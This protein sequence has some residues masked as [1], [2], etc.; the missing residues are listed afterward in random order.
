MTTRTVL[1]ATVILV[2]TWV[3]LAALAQQ[4]QPQESQQAQPAQVAASPAVSQTPNAAT[5]SQAPAAAAGGALANQDIIKLS[6][7]GLG[8][9]VIITK[10]NT[11]QQVAFKLDTDD[12]IALKNAGVNQDVIS[13]MM[14]RSTSPIAIPGGRSGGMVDTLGGPVAIPGAD[15]LLVRLVT[16][17][18]TTDLSSIAGHVGTTYAFVTVLMFMDY[19]N[20]KA[21]VRIKDP[22]PSILIQSRKSPQ[23]RFFLVRCESNDDDNNRSVKMGKSGMWSSKDLGAPDSDWTIRFTFKQV[24]PG[25]WRMDPEKDLNPGEYGV[26]GPSSEL[27]DFG[28]DHQ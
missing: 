7:I 17:D 9:D 5:V 25:L 20:L 1:F 16:K 14:K 27:Y 19:P 22:R 2:S 8:P 13:A 18:G 4:P 11:A 21:E 6:Q 24:Q 23:G 26:W 28:V 12:L 3:T 10:I 15:D